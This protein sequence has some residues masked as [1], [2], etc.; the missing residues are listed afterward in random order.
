MENNDIR[1]YVMGDKRYE[2]RA[3]IR[4]IVHGLQNVDG[5]VFV[6]ATQLL[7]WKIKAKTFVLLNQA[8]LTSWSMKAVYKLNFDQTNDNEKVK[9]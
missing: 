6:N 9:T 2:L 3:V 8:G 5:T 1:I 7:L 4:P